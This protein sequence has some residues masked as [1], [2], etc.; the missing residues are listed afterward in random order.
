MLTTLRTG[1]LALD[2]AVQYKFS[3]ADKKLTIRLT[4]DGNHKLY[5]DLNIALSNADEI[6]IKRPDGSLVE[7]YFNKTFKFSRVSSTV[8]E[9]SEIIESGITIAENFSNLPDNG[10]AIEA[11]IANDSFDLPAG[12]YNFLLLDTADSNFSTS[13]ISIKLL[14]IGKT[15]VDGLESLFNKDGSS[16]YL[17]INNRDLLFSYPARISIKN[18]NSG[19]TNI[20]LMIN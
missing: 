7:D 13:K 1:A 16:D 6:N 8:L 14:N 17:S 18:D 4:S 3:A 19:V 5:G 2:I 20:P 11:T 10:D 9:Y 15:G 12:R